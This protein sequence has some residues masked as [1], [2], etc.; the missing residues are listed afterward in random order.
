MRHVPWGR[1]LSAV[2]VKTTGACIGEIL[3]VRED[4]LGTRTWLADVSLG[5]NGRPLQIVLGGERKLRGG[6][7]V[8]VAPPGSWA[9]VR[10]AGVGE[11]RR[12][13][14]VRRYRGEAS[15]GMLCSLNELGWLHSGPDEVAVL[16]HL[17]P[18]FSL[19]GFPGSRRPEVVVD[20]ERAVQHQE[21]TETALP[22]TQLAA[23]SA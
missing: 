21:E 13:M 14:R 15:H 18:G 5:N 7:L 16:C 9:T 10:R 17:L 22:S 23:A 20:W 6:E 3:S 4:P 12:K 19:D 2:I 1:I 11:L 8:P